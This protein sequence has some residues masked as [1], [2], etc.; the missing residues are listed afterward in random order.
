MEYDPLESV[1]DEPLR[2]TGNVLASLRSFR[3]KEKIVNLPGVDPGAERA[4]LSDA[5]NRLIDNIA[6]G[7]EANPSKVW[8]LGQFQRSLVQ[9][10]DHDTEA[11]EHFGVELEEI[12]EILGIESSD[13]LLSF[14]LGGL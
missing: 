9:L 2:V 8:V 13:G 10:Q 11:R 4:R 1:I 6:L 7:I 12:M 5:V 3:R 14:Y